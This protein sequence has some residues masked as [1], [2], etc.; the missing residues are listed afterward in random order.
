[1]IIIVDREISENN[2]R[3][4]FDRLEEM[5]LR[6]TMFVEKNKT[7]IGVLGATADLPLDALE[8][9]PGVEKVMPVGKPY[10]AASREFKESD[11]LVKVG[12]ITIGQ[13]AFHVMAGPCA[14]ESEEQIYHIAEKVKGAGAVILR[15]GAYKPRTS[16]YS[17]QGLGEDGLKYLA[18]AGKEFGMPI[19]T[20]LLDLRDIDKVVFYTDIIQ[21]GARNMQNYPML[22][23][24]ARAQKPI[25]LKRGL[26]A[27]I[28]EW[29]L[30]A[31]Y[32]LQEGNSQVILCE[33]GI[34]TFEEYTRNTLDLSAVIAIK[35]LS[36]LPIIVDPS[37]GTGR[38]FMVSPLSRAATVL[39]AHGLIIEVHHNPSEALS[40][41]E[42]S[43]TPANFHG[44]MTDIS[45]LH[46]ACLGLASYPARV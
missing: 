21:I 10:K 44:L 23:E 22:R 15:G 28:G 14:V 12:D 16:P 39:G 26:C 25:L 34:R 30:A 29:L 45:S 36:H 13:G 40:D 1:M 5:G 31:E 32:I 6:H 43:L 4:V 7:V 18:G 46:L 33:R 24:A 11:T 41:G 9:I 27:T 17:F 35:H 20:E 3:I 19:V 37:H 2:L 8:S 42:Q 38:W